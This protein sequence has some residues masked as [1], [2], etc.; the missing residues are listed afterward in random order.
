MGLY[1][2][3]PITVSYDSVKFGGSRL[4]GSGD[5][6]NLSRDFERPRDQRVM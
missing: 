5:V 6:F 3:E 4:S 2:E 1:L